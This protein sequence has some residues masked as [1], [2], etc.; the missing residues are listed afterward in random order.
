VEARDVIR[1]A[2]RQAGLSQQA[3]ADRLGSPQPTIARW[4]T[5]V[6]QPTFAAVRDAARA[7]GLE[8]TLGLAA[9]DT[10]YGPQVIEQLGQ[11]PAERVRRLSPPG[12]FDRVELLAR[13]V[14]AGAQRMIVVGEVAGAL[15][16]W[17]LMLDGNVLELAPHPAAVHELETTLGQLGAERD[18][19]PGGLRLPDGGRVA[20]TALPPGTGG[21]RDLHRDAEDIELAPGVSVSVAS[22]VDLLRMADAGRAAGTGIF[23]PA[24]WRTLEITRKR[25]GVKRTAG[26]DPGAAAELLDAWLN[27]QSR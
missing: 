25:A 15:H 17:P 1:I 27:R 24:L 19:A 16:G 13:L 20:L 6:Q 23:L 4:E 22:L 21:F 26:G 5:G 3:L 11:S 10:S 9:R 8:L 2:R 18:I 12:S 14:A 7:C